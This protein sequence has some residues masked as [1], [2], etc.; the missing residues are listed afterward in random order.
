LQI[1][2]YLLTPLTVR[3]LSKIAHIDCGRSLHVGS[4]VF[5]PIQVAAM[6]FALI[7]LALLAASGAVCVFC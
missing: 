7:A 5:P 4:G 6:K 3:S 1:D 2:Y